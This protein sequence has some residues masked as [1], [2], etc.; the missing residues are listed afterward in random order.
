MRASSQHGPLSPEDEWLQE[1]ISKL[2]ENFGVGQVK[3]EVNRR[4]PP[5]ESGRPKL[6]HQMRLFTL[7]LIVRIWALHHNNSVDAACRH[8]EKL[9]GL[10]E[11]TREGESG[12]I[13]NAQSIRRL[14]YE[15]DSELDR[16]E[17]QYKNSV[18]LDRQEYLSLKERLTS[19]PELLIRFEFFAAGLS[20]ASE[21]IHYELVEDGVHQ[22]DIFHHPPLHPPEMARVNLG[23]MPVFDGPPSPTHTRHRYMR[24]S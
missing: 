13:T 19:Y 2:V 21:I 11:D 17:I 14:Y 1:T 18:R 9:G 16:Y 5:K 4:P 24:K 23:D 22:C 8:L 6:W 10:L 7:W 15:A 20:K 12:L 3:A